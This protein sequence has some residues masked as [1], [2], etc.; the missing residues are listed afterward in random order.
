MEPDVWEGRGWWGSLEEGESWVESEL[1]EVN[2]GEGVDVA[3]EGDVQGGQR[4]SGR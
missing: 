4:Q 1:F 3:V 2:R